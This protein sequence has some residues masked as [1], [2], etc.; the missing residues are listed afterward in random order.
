MRIV[1]AIISS[2]LEY[3]GVD[4]EWSP[5][6]ESWK[7]FRWKTTPTQVQFNSFLRVTTNN[8]APESSGF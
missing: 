7:L 5:E 3:F 6:E 4:I 8:F 2:K 1:I